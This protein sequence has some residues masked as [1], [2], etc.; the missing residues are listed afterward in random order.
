MKKKI[1]LILILIRFSNLKQWN[2][3]NN[4]KNSEMI[5]DVIEYD[6]N[7]FNIPKYSFEYPTVQWFIIN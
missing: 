2:V 1:E 7:E 6:Y 3:N 5:T 4:L